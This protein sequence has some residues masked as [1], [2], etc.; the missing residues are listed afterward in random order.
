MASVLEQEILEYF[1]VKNFEKSHKFLYEYSPEPVR[2]VLNNF[3]KPQDFYKTIHVAGTVAKGS[4]VKFLSQMLMIDGFRVGSFYSPHLLRI[5]ERIQLNHQEISDN[6][7]SKLW[8]F[9]KK[10][11][12]LKTLSFFDCI[13]VMAFLYFKEKQV[14]WAVI[15]TGL[16][17]R[18]DSTNNLKTCF[19]VITPIGFDHQQ[20][21][22]KSLEKIA[23]A[24]AGIINS[25]IVFSYP[26]KDEAAEVL[27]Q[28]SLKYKGSLKFYSPNEKHIKKNYIEK[29]LDV[30]YWIYSEYFKKTPPIIKPHFKGRLEVLLKFPHIVF[31]SAHNEPAAR[32]LSF[33]LSDQKN[34]QKWILYLNTLKS[35][36]L[37]GIL[38]NLNFYAKDKIERIYFLDCFH[39]KGNFHQFNQ[40]E[41]DIQLSL[42]AVK[43]EQEFCNLLKIFK[44]AHLICGSMYLYKICA[45]LN[46]IK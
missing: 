37:R 12:N 25:Q 45:R 38:A 19:S 34:D 44:Y 24:K 7:L 40:L 8:Q 31:D 18:K 46:I 9:M 22:G 30:C 33:W 42:I 4:T 29:N 43:T 17:G 15:E 14:D 39:S 36:S 27:I 28:E 16:G 10:N 11:C 13:C 5:N 2:K 23:F 1:E 41:N 6:A 21:L 20:I 35:K 32:E 26:Q 3:L